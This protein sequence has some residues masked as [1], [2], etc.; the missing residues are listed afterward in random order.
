MK[1]FFWLL[2]AALFYLGTWLFVLVPERFVTAV[3]SGVGLAMRR[4]LPGR[5][6]IAEENIAKTLPHMRQQPGWC[7][8]DAAPQEI[9]KEVFRNIGRSLV[10]VCRLYHGRGTAVFQRI[11]VRNREHFEAAHAGGKGLIFLTGHCGNWEL[12]ALA[13]AHLFKTPVSVVARRQNNPYLNALVERMRMRYD[14][15]LIYKDN[16]LRNMLAVI[17]QNGLVGLLVDQAVLPDEGCLIEFLG[18]KAWASKTPA[19]LARKTGVPILPAF[20]HREGERHVIEFYPALEFSGSADDD[21]LIADVQRYSSAIERFIVEHPCDW[22]WVHRR[23]KR[24][25]GL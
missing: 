6:R 25:E 10:E 24:A 14:N 20:I 22:Y 9:A 5:R 1:R 7:L 3:G 19:L 17:R 23:W 16:A 12:L 13:Y 18:R 15:R 4:L 11:E 8:G 21:N 2:Q